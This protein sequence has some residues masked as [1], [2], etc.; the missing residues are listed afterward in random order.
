VLQVA[1]RLQNLDTD[2]T[3]LG[4]IAATAD[5]LSGTT[6]SGFTV[7]I[8]SGK[9]RIG[10]SS[11]DTGTGDF[12]S[13]FAPPATSASAKT[14]T[15]PDT[16]GNV[17]V[18]SATQTLT[19]KTL[20]ASTFTGTITLR[21][22]TASSGAYNINLGGSTGTFITPTG[23]HTISGAVTLAADV[24]ITAATG[25][26]VLDF[27]ASSGAFSTGTG[28]V[29]I[30]GNLVAAADVTLDWSASSGTFT[31]STGNN[32][33]SGNV[34]ISGTKTFA[35][36]TGTVT[37]SG[38]IT[39]SAGIDL[40]CEA[41]NTL[42]DFYLGTGI[43]RTTRGANTLG[44]PTTIAAVT[45]AALTIGTSTTIACN[46]NGTVV[47]GINFGS[48]TPTF[49]AS[50]G[51]DN[52]LF[53]IGTWAT[54]LAITLASDHWVPVQVN[55]K[56]SGDAA[57]DVAAMRLRCDTGAAVATANQHVL[58]LRQNLSHNVASSTILSASTT[59]GG[60]VTVGTGSILGG[61]FSFEGT[62]AI[63]AAG[64]NPINLLNVSN[65]HTG[66]GVTEIFNVYMGGT[67][68]TVAAMAQFNVGAGTATAGV[69]IS[70]T[71]GTLTTGLSF[72]GTQATAISMASAS[73]T[74]INVSGVVAT[75]L[76]VSKAAAT[77]AAIRVGDW[78]GSA[79]LGSAVPFTTAG[80]DVYEDGQLD[81][82]AVFG[83]STADYTS[84]YSAKCGRF[85][86]VINGITCSHEAYGLIG[87]V[88]AK[89]VTYAHLH[90]G[91]MGTFEVNTA[92]TVSAGDGVGCAGVIARV[93]GA[94]ITV[95]ATGVLAGVLSAQ[96]AT[97]VSI[98][99]GGVH[100]AFACRKVGAGITWAEALHIEDALVAIRFKAADN[101][102]AHGVKAVV[103]TPDTTTTHAIKVMIGT[104]AGY[105]PVYANETFGAA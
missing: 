53:A 62:G 6:A 45:G 66:G 21:A 51:R 70:R 59:I 99:S 102:Y 40:A 18:D 22:I 2:G 42:V 56:N 74:G 68:T 54:P 52:A 100:A 29:T 89:N 17:V 9:P 90:A 76:K 28:T 14:W 50:T 67:T 86:H 27:S 38:D 7:N 47:K 34:S 35:T 32:V 91:L 92:A 65:L 61:Y 26:G 23:A 84:A 69:I 36:G 82:V 87:Q 75:V 31:T 24:G 1:E 71:A 20:G 39:V 80:H 12:T 83:E 48:C 63:T 85:R 4:T 104:T 8:G 105:I 103:D 10:L 98:T 81:L 49:T 88:V 77:A 33:L 60:A 93:G 46:F 94:T 72:T 55:I 57:F 58:Q 30:N 95:G 44:G 79:A 37:L 64:T 41:G 16:T 101:S 15:M 25:T 3:Y 13:L 5:D 78:V 96:L 43:F 73:T 19:N 11:P 97:T